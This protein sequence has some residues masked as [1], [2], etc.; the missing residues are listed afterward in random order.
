MTCALPE[1]PPRGKDGKR[2]WGRLV[3]VTNPA[4]GR[5]IVCQQTDLGPG[6]K[7]RARG[8][9]VD[10]TP[11]AFEA[12]GGKLSEGKIMVKVEMVK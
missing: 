6:R 1:R 7:A 2:V 10:L 12:I 3:R 5:T 9:I 4:T 8:V 11:A